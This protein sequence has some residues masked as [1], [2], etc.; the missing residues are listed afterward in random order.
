MKTL[1]FVIGLFIVAFGAVVIIAPSAPI[2]IAHRADAPLYLYI[3]AA[4]RV[5]FGVLLL[6]VVS[7]SRTPRT[8]RVVALI[9][10]LAAIAM[11]IVGAQRASGH[12][13][14]CGH[15]R[16]PGSFDSRGFH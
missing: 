6:S 12:D 5:A 13:S 15:S 16:G 11:P 2:L 8:L 9:P 10:I 7:A 3:I 14:V 4:I 1:V